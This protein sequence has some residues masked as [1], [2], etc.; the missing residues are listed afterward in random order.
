MRLRVGAI[1][2]T[3]LA[4]AAAPTFAQSTVTGGIKIGVNFSKLTFSEEGDE[5]LT[6]DSRTGLAVGG[7]VDVPITEL[8]S[9]QPEVLYSQ[10]GG[11]QEIPGLGESKVKIDMIQIPL[12]F[13]ASF[14]GTAVRPFVVAGPAFGFVTSAKIEEPDVE[15]L[16]IKDDVAS[17]DVSGVIGAGLQF[18]R[19]IVEFRYD[20]G[21]TD[22]DDDEEDISEAKGKTW[23][24]LFGYGF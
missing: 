8:F 23:T 4:V 2:V 3:I 11:K 19:G 18:G 17:V 24:I 12:L 1:L 14:A 20:H 16:D 15:D 21:F 13:K 22:L 7:F 5:D 6:T 9:F 10:K